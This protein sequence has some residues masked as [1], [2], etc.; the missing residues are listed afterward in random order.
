MVK[1]Q[2]TIYNKKII[3]PKLRK[4]IMTLNPKYI[5]PNIDRHNNEL[6]F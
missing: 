4:Y 1:S 3:A 2:L 5:L 6:I